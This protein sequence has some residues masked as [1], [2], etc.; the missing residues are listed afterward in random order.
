MKTKITILSALIVMIFASCGNNSNQNNKSSY[1]KQ[2]TST[3]STSN[4]EAQQQ[5]VNKL[6]AG[7]LPVVSVTASNYMAQS[8]VYKY[9]PDMATDDNMQTW[10]SP[11]RPKSDG[12]NSWIQIG[13]GGIKNVSEVEI[14]NGSH[15]PNYPKYGNL[16]M[17]NNRLMKARV[18][19]S[20]GSNQTISLKEIDDIQKINITSVNTSY[21]KLVPLDMGK[22]NTWDDLCISWFKAIGE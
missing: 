7:V 22:G 1:D 15:F 19:F 11:A 18:E 8:G 5:V 13:F 20:D 14:L 17:R 16:Y 6:P 4:T 3:N 2:D 9:T 10:W 21:V 12:H